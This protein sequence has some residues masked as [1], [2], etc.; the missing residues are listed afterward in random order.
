MRVFQV[1]PVLAGLS[2]AFLIPAKVSDEV[3]EAFRTVSNALAEKINGNPVRQTIKL[4]C[5]GCPYLVGQTNGGEIKAYKKIDN[6]LVS[7][8]CK[9]EL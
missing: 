9:T 8:F 4:E 7:C 5:K 3:A 1:L 6:A 2:S